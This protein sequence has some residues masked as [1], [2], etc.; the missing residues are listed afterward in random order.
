MKIELENLMSAFR[1]GLIERFSLAADMGTYEEIDQQIK[2]SIELKG[3]NAVTLILAIFIASVGLNVNSSAVIIGAMLVSPLMGPISGVGYGVAVYDFFL[4]R[5]S[6]LNLAVATGV[7]LITSTVYFSITP[8]TG[9][10]SELLARTSPSV[11]DVVIAILGGLAGAIG[12]TRKEK[13]N[14]VPGVAI[15]TALMPPLCTAGFGI[16]SGNFEFFGGALY[17]FFINS[18][19]IAVAYAVVINLLRVPHKTFVDKFVEQ[20][21]RRTLFAIVA[22]TALP[23]L[24][25]AYHL[26]R[27]EIFKNAARD[28][29]QKEI[30]SSFVQVAKLD[31]DPKSKRIDVTLIGRAL[32]RDDIDRI[33][34][35]LAQSKVAGS[36]LKLYQNGDLEFDVSALKNEIVQNLQINSLQLI[37]ERDRRISELETELRKLN[38]ESTENERFIRELTVQYPTLRNVSVGSA[39]TL[40]NGPSGSLRSQNRLLVLG[41]SQRLSKDDRIRLSNW[42]RVR[43]EDQNAK[44]VFEE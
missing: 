20:R 5:K 40:S 24:Y 28:F 12:S 6:L 37:Q 26:V 7:S 10:Q 13:S 44:V 34:D 18:V 32:K 31:V 11:W 1:T 41:S 35:R 4:I 17:L 25:L 43:M 27:G 39:L 30:R 2:S 22:I 21:V 23:S 14:V 3:A 33:H 16:A 36:D 9:E 42:F 19:F 15:A 8:L 38:A 29:V